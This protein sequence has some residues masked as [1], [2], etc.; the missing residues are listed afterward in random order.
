MVPVVF[1]PATFFSGA[2]LASSPL[3]PT[4]F[5]AIFFGSALG[6]AFL[7]AFFP[8]LAGRGGWALPRGKFLFNLAG[9][10]TVFFFVADLFFFALDED[11]FIPLDREMRTAERL[12]PS[13]LSEAPTDGGP[14]APQ[15]L[16]FPVSSDS[17]RDAL[18]VEA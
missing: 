12:L 10:P 6:V 1:S 4:F 17:R 11:F 2:S 5:L 14:S 18:L 3:S 13:V 9:P 7:A 8:P 15:R 16:S